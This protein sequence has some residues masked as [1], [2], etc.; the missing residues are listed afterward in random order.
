M[1]TL[2]SEI[3]C[4]VPLLE[5]YGVQILKL[6]TLECDDK[7]A[8]QMAPNLVRRHRTK[9]IAVDCHFTREKVLEGL[10]LS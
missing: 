7:S 3:T 8:L 9:H 10:F 1:E 4:I 2:A 6:I 5:E